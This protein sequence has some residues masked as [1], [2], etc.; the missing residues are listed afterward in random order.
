MRNPFK[1]LLRALGL[2]LTGR[3]R[4][5]RD[6]ADA[7]I[8]IDGERFTA[9]RK[10]TVAPA[11]DRPSRPGALFRVRFRFKNLS[12][13]ANRRLSL[14]PIPLIVAQPGFRSKT[15]LVGQ[16]GGEFIGSYEFDTVAQAEAYRS[17]LPLGMMRKRAAPGSL[18]YELSAAR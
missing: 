11:G 16:R 3:T 6:L 17:S 18:S 8:E 12:F 15:W 5:E 10:V 4:F 2:G 1:L 9:F 14:I 7:G 13:A